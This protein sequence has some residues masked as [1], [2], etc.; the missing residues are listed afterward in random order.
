MPLNP[1][2]VDALF[3]RFA[4]IWPRAWADQF[5]G[6][7]R[8]LLAAE[9]SQGLAGLTGDQIKRGIERCRNDKP[10]PPSIAEFRE[11]ARDGMN[12]EQRALAARLEQE[13]PRA[14]PAVTRAELLAEGA[15]RAG[16][17][18]Q[19]ATPH[20]QRTLKNIAAGKWTREME[21]SYRKSCEHLSVA[22]VEPEWPESA[23]G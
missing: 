12:A 8:G 5:G 17:V 19:A 13:T 18:K 7:D 9:W 23:H 20:I 22:C 4:V 15:K 21:A 10:W 1:K 6:V 2:W 11:A 14:L 16:E 3:A